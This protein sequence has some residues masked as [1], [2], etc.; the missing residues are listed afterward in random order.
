MQT[1]FQRYVSHASESPERDAPPAATGNCKEQELAR[2][3]DLLLAE[4]AAWVARNLHKLVPR[5]AL[6]DGAGRSQS[7][8]ADGSHRK[9]AARCSS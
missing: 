5:S 8:S 9:A 7:T 1:H 2:R 6:P 4:N 3:S